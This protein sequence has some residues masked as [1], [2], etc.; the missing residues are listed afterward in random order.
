MSQ[1]VP[2]QDVHADETHALAQVGQR[3]GHLSVAIAEINGLVAELTILGQ[4]QNRAA[5]AAT[6]DA[7]AMR[8][9]NSAL[10][11][12]MRTTH[13]AG[14][15]TSAILSENT[16]VIAEALQS[17][18]QALQTL[19]EGS[20]AV[21]KALGAAD[22]RIH[23]IQQGSAAIE[24]I[25]QET[26]LLALNASVEAARA[27][28]AG[29]GFAVIANAVKTLADQIKKFTG[30]NAQHIDSLNDT[31]RSLLE[32]SNANAQFAE[33]TSADAQ[34]A[35]KTNE[36]L[37]TLAQSVDALVSDIKAMA[38]PVEANTQSF[39]SLGAH[40][41]EMVENI[42]LSHSKLDI[43]NMRAEA[44]LKISEDFMVFVA[45][46]GI[47]TDDTRFIN[48]VQNAALE[49]SGLLE[50]CLKSGEIS[51][52]HLFAHDY[53]VI[54]HSNPVQYLTPSLRFTDRH[55]PA[56]QEPMLSI[57]PRVVFC[58][59]VDCNAFLPTHNKVFAQTPRRDPVWNT[60]NCRNR[61]FFDDRTGLAAAK[62]TKPF[63]LQTYRRDMGN[64][65]F[66]LMK[67]VSAPIMVLGKHWGGL[68]LA[69]RV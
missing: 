52:A 46:S 5:Q 25:A 60:A 35:S 58:A 48:A 32:A 64:G 23:A 22:A 63:L 33:K 57:D 50:K 18:N 39:A 55:F 21:H 34:S 14:Q 12:S 61:R 47:E 24:S 20:M 38:E 29:R 44:I 37:R 13:E 43:A 62:N 9:S 51:A 41:D 6:E 16:Q 3:A 19:G 7:N 49:M 8:A 2:V 65:E 68:R 11:A 53:R 59:A 27:G 66:A 67:D 28:D 69:Y 45:D 56:I 54:E 36:Q 42:T 4:D 40:L 15:S 17:T 10:V 30:E 26:Q 1:S 31:M